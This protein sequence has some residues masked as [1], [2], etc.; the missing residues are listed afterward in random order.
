MLPLNSGTVFRPFRGVKERKSPG[1]DN[2]SGRLLK[3]CAEP[4]ASM[5]FLHR[6]KVCSASVP[7][8]WKDSVIVPVPE[9]TVPKSLND[10]RHVALTS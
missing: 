8:I 4:L 3:N 2:V 1:P 7:C 5:F 10:F 6:Y 9:I